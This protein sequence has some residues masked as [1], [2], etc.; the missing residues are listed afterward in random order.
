MSH[1]ATESFYNEKISYIREISDSGSL[2]LVEGVGTGSVQNE[3]ILNQALGF[4]FDKNLYATFA[5]IAHLQV[6]DNQ[7]ILKEIPPQQ[8]ENRDMNLDEIASHLAP[9]IT[10]NTGWVLPD[11]TLLENIIEEMNMQERNFI[12]YV[13]RSFLNWSL[14]N[15][16]KMIATVKNDK[17]S[18]FHV[19]LDKRN[20]RIVER[21][22]GAN[23][24][25]IIVLYWALHF[26]WVLEQLK[27]VDPKWKIESFIPRAPYRD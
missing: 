23:E 19:L 12:K 17:K 7:R 3:E 9:H 2:F 1:V 6:Q 4:Q 14:K 10:L 15:S 24:D 18:L 5:D 11:S 25:T 20:Q 8:I 21:I 22:E 13:F 16:D 27:K 26:E